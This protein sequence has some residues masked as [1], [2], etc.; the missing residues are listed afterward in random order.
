MAHEHAPVLTLPVG[1]RDHSEG[2]ADAAV[3]LVEYGDYECPHCGM[4]YPII[5]EVQ[6]RMGKQLRFVFRNFPIPDN[7]PHAIH[8]A[9]AAE[10]AGAQDRFWPMH[11]L[12]YEH[13]QKLRDR[14][15]VEHA[16]ALG[17]DAERF[18]RE[19]VAPRSPAARARGR[20][21][22]RRKRRER[23]ADVFHQW[24]QVRR[25]LGCGHVDGVADTCGAQSAPQVTEH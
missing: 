10:A 2:P 23:H 19:L 12:L 15:L 17:L 1:S 6:R 4:A 13:Q 18:Q 5:K 21:E 20:H 14:H 24:G 8:A 7:H 16:Q 3:T 22:R 9:E 25:E 11:D